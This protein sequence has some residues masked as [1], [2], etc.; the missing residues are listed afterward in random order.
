M[1]V[2][3][4]NIVIVGCSTGIGF[5][6][7]KYFKSTSNTVIGMGLHKPDIDIDFYECDVTDFIS[8]TNACDLIC[9]KYD[10]IDGIVYNAGVVGAN[11]ICDMDITV[12]DHIQKVNLYGYFYVAKAFYNKLKSQGYGSIVQI[13]SKSGKKGSY[14]NCAYSSSKFAGIGLTQSLALEFVEFGVRVNCVCPGNV[15]E[16][17]IWQKHLFEQFSKTQKL[18]KDQLLEK[19]IN[20][21]PMKRGCTYTDVINAVEFLLSDKSSYMTGQAIN[22]TGGQQ[23]S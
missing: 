2:K 7:A 15:F 23:L 8:V 4:N 19:Y 13:N 22:I 9:S 11:A 6:L 1:T 14:K 16:S 5:E 21:V 20:L 18:N 10:T 17:D 3:G 12:F